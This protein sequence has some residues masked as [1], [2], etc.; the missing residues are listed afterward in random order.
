VSPPAGWP[1][2]FWSAFTRSKNAMV[3]IDD[4]RRHVDVNGAYL[5][6]VG[7]RREALIGRPVYDFVEGGRKLDDDEWQRALSHGDAYG[8]VALVRGDARVVQV[9]Y[10]AH[11]E[12]VTGRRLI[13]FVVLHSNA[14]RG[15]RDP[16]HPAGR[17]GVL[18]D[19]ERQIVRLIAIGHSGPEI[20]AELHISHATVRTHVRNAQDKLGARSRAQL[21]AMALGD[22]DVT[23]AADHAVAVST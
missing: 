6:L 9:E 20:A 8:D 15:A 12:V 17:T 22:G 10:A 21:V 3:L 2:L 19:R 18:S 23:F 7:Y 4:G 13:L 16:R 5:A 11:P 14:R 1:A